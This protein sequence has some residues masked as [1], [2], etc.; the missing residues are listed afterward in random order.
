MKSIIASLLLVFILGCTNTTPKSYTVKV[1]YINSNRP[2]TIIFNSY[3]T[4]KLSIESGVS[5]LY[6]GNIIIA[7]YVRK[8]KI[9]KIQ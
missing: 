1:E 3:Q 4:P 8:F 7:S 5:S 6:D 2:D 9:L